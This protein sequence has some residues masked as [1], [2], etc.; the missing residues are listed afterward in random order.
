LGTN[1]VGASILKISEGKKRAKFGAISNV[2]AFWLITCGP[3]GITSPD[4][5]TWYA[6]RQG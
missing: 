3:V 4:L 6:V 5:S 1:F 2:S